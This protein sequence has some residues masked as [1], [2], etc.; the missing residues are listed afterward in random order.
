MFELPPISLHY[1][2]IS[3]ALGILVVYL[4]APAPDVVVRFPTPY[5]AGK[6]TYE[7]RAGTCY[8]YSA[9]KVECDNKTEGAV[10]PQPIVED[11]NREVTAY[12]EDDDRLAAFILD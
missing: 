2:I 1:F 12:D 3:F 11:F 5:N 4:L 8:Q 10:L 7:D 6:V 9:T